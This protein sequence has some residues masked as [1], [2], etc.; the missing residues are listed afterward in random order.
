MYSIV[1]TLSRFPRTVLRVVSTPRVWYLSGYHTLLDSFRVPPRIPTYDIRPPREDAVRLVPTARGTHELLASIGFL[2]VG[3]LAGHLWRGKLLRLLAHTTSCR[4]QWLTRPRPQLQ[5]DLVPEEG[6]R[7]APESAP[8]VDEN[9][10]PMSATAREES[11]RI[12]REEAAQRNDRVELRKREKAMEEKEA[13]LTAAANH[14]C[15]PSGG[16]DLVVMERPKCAVKAALNLD[17]TPVIRPVQ[18]TR[19]ELAGSRVAIGV[20]DP[21]VQQVKADAELLKRFKWEGEGEG[22]GEG[23]VQG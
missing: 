19:A 22:E 12:H 6:R 20:I 21:S 4:S 10:A 8:A 1:S 3:V 2:P 14:R 23:E 9:S 7:G 11:A 18:R 5:P 13:V 15:N 17:G 16:A